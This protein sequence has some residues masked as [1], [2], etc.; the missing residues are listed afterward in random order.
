MI[1]KAKT[2]SLLEQLIEVICGLIVALFV[3]HISIWALAMMMVVKRRL[4]LAMELAEVHVSDTIEGRL[5]RKL[6]LWVL[7]HCFI[8]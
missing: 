6:L 5:N 4:L 7:V 3:I 8:I 2:L 1:C